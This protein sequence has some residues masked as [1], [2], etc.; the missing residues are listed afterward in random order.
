MSVISYVVHNI[1]DQEKVKKRKK[2]YIRIMDF[3]K[4][5]VSQHRNVLKQGLWRKKSRYEICRPSIECVIWEKTE[6]LGT[7]SCHLSLGL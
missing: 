6:L 7:V 4:G 1:S 3:N 2:K 5:S